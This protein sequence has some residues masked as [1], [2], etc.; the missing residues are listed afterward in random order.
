MSIPS[1]FPPVV[2][3]TYATSPTPTK[4]ATPTAPAANASAGSK[5]G[6]TNGTTNANAALAADD[7]DW[8]DDSALGGNVD[9]TA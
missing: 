1:Q 6:N 2:P 3:S 5:A 9:T 8:P 7:G 4:A